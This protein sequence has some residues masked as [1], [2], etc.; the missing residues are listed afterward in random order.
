M[1]KKDG[2]YATM[3]TFDAK[4]NSKSEPAEKM[5]R[6][7]TESTSS[8]LSEIEEEKAIQKEAAETTGKDLGWTA[9]FKFLRHC[10]PVPVQML[11]FLAM[12]SFAI[13]RLGTSIWLQVTFVWTNHV[14][15]VE[16]Q[17]NSNS[18]GVGR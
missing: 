11:L 6:R 18:P 1:A 13:L 9:L 10:I 14:A 15:V 5:Q 16:I 8:A 4:R 17:F 12:S 2:S 7:R 3:A